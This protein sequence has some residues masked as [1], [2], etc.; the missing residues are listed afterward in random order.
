MRSH[1]IQLALSPEPVVD[2]YRLCVVKMLRLN[3][4][5][6]SQMSDSGAVGGPAASC[7]RGSATDAQG[8]H[9]VAI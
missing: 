3:L 6:N 7:E 8:G 1:C 4:A 9:G 5:L 2:D